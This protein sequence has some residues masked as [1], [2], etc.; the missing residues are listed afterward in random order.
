MNKKVI[1]AVFVIAASGVYKSAVAQKPITPVVMGA[2]IFLLVLSI[3]D[4]FGG[5]MSQ[6]AGGLAMLAA[7]GT[8]LYDFPWTTISN[9][10]TGKPTATPVAPKPTP[11]PAPSIAK[12]P[13]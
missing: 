1:A 13:V 4:M 12:N 9:V 11:Q 8:L 10:V 2:Y 5:A 7:V 3:M 6:L